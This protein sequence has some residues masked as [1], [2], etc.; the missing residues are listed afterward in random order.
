MRLVKSIL[1]CNL[2]TKFFEQGVYNENCKNFYLN[3]VLKNQMAEF[4][5]KKKKKKQQ[6]NPN[7]G[8][9]C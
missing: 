2:K 9:L 1:D 5:E 3:L 6:E 4:F 7:F 8:P